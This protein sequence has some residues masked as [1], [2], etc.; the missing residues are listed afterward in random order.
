[1]LRGKEM[2]EMSPLVIHSEGS[3]A[4]LY[5]FCI[6]VIHLTNSKC[7]GYVIGCSLDLFGQKST[8]ETTKF[9]VTI[10]F[11]QVRGSTPELNGQ[12]LKL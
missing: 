10:S 7:F 1:M 8:Q 9:I 12:K 5:I 11:F 2:L 4:L 3:L 6:I